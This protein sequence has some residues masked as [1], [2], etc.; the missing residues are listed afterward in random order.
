M[1]GRPIHFDDGA[2][3][4]RVMGIWSRIAGDAFLDWLAPSPGLRWIDV[5]CGNGA[6]SEAIATRCAPLTLDGVDPSEAQLAFARRRTRD[7]TF[8][9]GDAMALPFT[10]PSFDVA[11]MALVIFFVPDPAKGVAEMVRVVRPGGTAAAYAWDIMGG[12]YPMEPIIEEMRAIGLTPPLSP[13]PEVSR[14]EALRSLW[15]E[16][17][18][19]EIET[20]EI[21]VTRTFDD[22]EDFWTSNMA[23]ATGKALAELPAG[24][25]AAL[26]ERVRAR[27]PADGAGRIV[28]S[29]RANAVKGRVPG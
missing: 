16:A 3:Y 21:A 20:R 1:M 27:M 4:E 18:L 19:D 14:I 6:F 11:V 23:A 15:H 24:E 25:Q 22:F 7:A 9:R 17:G 26:K 2:A 8:Q 28:G 29:G 13:R 10:S 5:G 12:G